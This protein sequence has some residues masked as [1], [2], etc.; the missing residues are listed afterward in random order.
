[1]KKFLSIIF[2]GLLLSGNAYAKD[3]SGL[4]LYCEE[5]PGFFSKYENFIA[6]DFIDETN[7]VE[8]E[9]EDGKLI[10]R[11]NKYEV[12]IDDIKI[13]TTD[14]LVF[15]TY[16]LLNRKKLSYGSSSGRGQTCKE[17]K[18][19]DEG[20]DL[21]IK[22]EDLLDRVREKKNKENKI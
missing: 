22:M 4:K 9:I 20:T 10:T 8:Y 5:W 11:N 17:F 13:I 21:L 15:N 1:M 2:L 14:A 19:V 16:Q 18:K 12:N 6:L 3:L 7:V